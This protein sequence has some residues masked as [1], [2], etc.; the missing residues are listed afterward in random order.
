MIS[1]TTG[2]PH[3]ACPERIIASIGSD[4]GGAIEDAR[5]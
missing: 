5:A 4:P 1:I 3:G 2:A